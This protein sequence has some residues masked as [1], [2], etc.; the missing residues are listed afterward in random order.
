MVVSLAHDPGG[1]NDFDT[2]Y[3]TYADGTTWGMNLQGPGGS[4]VWTQLPA[5]PNGLAIS[6]LTVSAP[7]PGV[8][9]QSDGW[10]RPRECVSDRVQQQTFRHGFYPLE[11]AAGGCV[12]STFWTNV[13]L[14]PYI[15]GGFE[16]RWLPSM[17]KI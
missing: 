15:F 12:V 1:L 10:V 17:E 13:H 2:F 14:A 5:L 11:Q 3:T 7:L 16:A 6:G 4:A 9:R 8:G